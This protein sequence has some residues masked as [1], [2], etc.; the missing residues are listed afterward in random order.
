VK[1]AAER[2]LERE[3]AR[4]LV[5]ALEVALSAG[6]ALAELR[7]ARDAAQ[8][9]ELPGLDRLVSALAP[10]TSRPWPAEIQP[11]VER[12]QRVC[13]RAT[14]G[15]GLAEF[16]RADS[17]FHGLAGEIVAMEWSSLP[18]RGGASGASVP[19]LSA[20]EMLSDLPL[21]GDA[22]A[23]VAR[24]ARLTMPVAA[25]VRAALDWLAGREGIRQPLELREDASALEIACE[26]RD[27]AGVPPAHEVLSGVDGNLG[28]PLA[29][30]GEAREGAWILRVPSFSA[31]P[32]YVMLEQGTL[33]LAVPWHAVLRLQ[34]APRDA[35]ATRAARLGMSVLPPLS[36]LLGRGA[37]SP[38][39]IVAHG[40]RRAWMVADR[41]V[42]R[43]P[44][45]ACAPDE[46]I[47]GAGL[48]RAVI[49]DEGEVFG[50]VETAPLLAGLPLPPLPRVAAPRTV[51][52]EPRTLPERAEIEILDERWV[53][54]LPA[55]AAAP[56]DTVASAPGEA[57]RPDDAVEPEADAE[58]AEPAAGGEPRR[59]AE[60][61]AGGA[62]RA[63]VA[64]D[65]F[66]A[67][68]FL[69]RL[70][71]QQG[72]EVVAVERAAELNTALSGGP[73]SL[74]CVDAELPDAHG[75][76]LL[77]D[78][79]TRLPEPVPLVALVRDDQDL[80]AARVAGVWRTLLKPVEPG[81]LRRLLA[82]LGLEE[83][84]SG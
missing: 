56:Q 78:V 17:D 36:P 68:I 3:I 27:S 8:L 49:T 42:W 15:G 10:H 14:S 19:T 20:A 37:E 25:A 45:D 83:R 33:R 1:P 53:T 81:A 71:E 82:R 2:D 34:V 64:E 18:A 23:S 65:S 59:D 31:R 47:A 46:R 76:G 44:A 79:R 58:P 48:T 67:R 74:V 28:P 32:A 51:A 77:R 7:A 66:T 84:A 11:V 52:P 60:A 55:P 61:A 9:L 30:W 5:G 39:V 6:G 41:L 38:V 35:I 26:L 40:L 43:L 24:R 70:L 62:R 57:V 12:L 4:S 22:S 21:A 69:T 13:A 29:A 80:A 50:L 73:W 75:A 54:P 72:F 16:R 63:L